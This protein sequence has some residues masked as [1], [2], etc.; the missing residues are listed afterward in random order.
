MAYYENE[1]LD[2]SL[3]LNNK[4]TI[5]MNETNNVD[6]GLSKMWSYVERS[7]GSLKRS[8]VNVYTSGSMGSKIRN[9]ETGEYYNDIVGSLDEDLYFKVAIATGELK[10]KNGS[11]TLFYTS[12]EHY[13]SH[14]HSNLTL[15]T[16]NKWQEKRHDRLVTINKSKS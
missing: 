1:Y 8:K 16:I 6:R 14:L 11:N 15:E 12:P 10:A 13:M 4:H 7:D 3:N 2:D 5:L 9:A